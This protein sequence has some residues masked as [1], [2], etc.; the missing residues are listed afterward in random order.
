M[1]EHE[2]EEQMGEC[3]EC[4]G[5]GPV[6]QECPTCEEEYLPVGD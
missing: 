1:S 3:P 2:E 5:E 6:Y 4:G